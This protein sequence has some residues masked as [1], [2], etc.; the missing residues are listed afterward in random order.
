MEDRS[1]ALIAIIFLI[2]LAVGS[3]GIAFWMQSGREETRQYL[4]ISPYGVSGLK[5]QAPVNFKGITVGTVRAVGLDPDNPDRVRIRIAV[6]SRTPVTRA[7]YAEV[8]SNGI[9]GVSNVTLQQSKEGASPLKTSE[10]NPA[11][12]PM[13]RSLMQKLTSSGDQVKQV[14][15]E[16]KAIS[17]SAKEMLSED[18]RAHVAAILE[19]LDMAT[20]KLVTLEDQLSPALQR[21]PALLD[22]TQET[23]AQSEALLKQ[24]RSDAASFHRLLGTTN[25]MAQM[26]ANSTVPRVDILAQKL[27]G[28]IQNINQLTQSLQRN[29]QK[30][31]FGNEQAPP[32]PGEP[33]YV[34]PAKTVR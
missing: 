24:A 32:G 18:N 17:D 13:H 12:I 31:I 23:L 14:V 3:A 28:T 22:S 10:G 21:L 34:P 20:Q 11:T 26:L 8:S 25:D 7:T 6:T 27:D 19:H 4:I 29:P 9:T 15:S 1:H 5:P 2:V 16:V 33:G 30:V